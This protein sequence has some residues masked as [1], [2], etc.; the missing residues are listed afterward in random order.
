[1]FKLKPMMKM[2]MLINTDNDG[3]KN[4]DSHNNETD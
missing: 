2:T 3:N 4:D 1:M